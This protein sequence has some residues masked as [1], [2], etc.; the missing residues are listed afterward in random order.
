MSNMSYC[1]F[2]NT[3]SDLIDC[4][5]SIGELL[6]GDDA[7]KDE[8]KACRRLIEVCKRIASDYGDCG[9]E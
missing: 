1:R 8:L 7:N 5:E 4:E 9:E 6:D 2:R 3:L